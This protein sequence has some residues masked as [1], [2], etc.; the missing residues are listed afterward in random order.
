[1]ESYKYRGT[2]HYISQVQSFASGFAKRMLVLKEQGESKYPN[3]A[4]FE[5]TR[6]KDGTKDGTKMLDKLLEGMEVEVSFYPSA[7]ESKTKPGSWFTSNRAV[8]LERIGAAEVTIPTKD[9]ADGGEPE[10]DLDDMP[11]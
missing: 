6:S 1:M 9:D 5:F 3:Y 10:P 11:F 8:K 4:A 7:N 2:V